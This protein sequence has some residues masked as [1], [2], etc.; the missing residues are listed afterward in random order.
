M[1]IIA[2]RGLIEG[3][4]KE[5]ENKPNTIQ[6]ALDYGF[7]VEVD[8]W[9]LNDSWYLGHDGPEYETNIKFLS[10]QKMWIHCKNLNALSEITSQHVHI[11]CFWHENDKYTLT[12]KGYIW[13]Y[14]GQET[15]SNKSIKV[16]PELHSSISKV[17]NCLGICTDYALRY[18]NI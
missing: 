4:N 11:N 14:P 2:H 10:N 9:F 6:K 18:K 13:A 1:L 3:P 7:D 17:Q 16:L 12:S 5:I 15:Q 8:V